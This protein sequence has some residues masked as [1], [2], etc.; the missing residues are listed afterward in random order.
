MY[1]MG[2]EQ[3]NRPQYPSMGSYQRLLSPEEKFIWPLGFKAGNRIS[4]VIQLHSLMRCY[5]FNKFSFYTRIGLCPI[6]ILI[7]EQVKK[8]WTCEIMLHM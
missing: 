5:Q 1:C 2:E 7:D 6:D 4:L 8:T 3:C